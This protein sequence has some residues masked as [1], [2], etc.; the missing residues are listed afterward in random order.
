MYIK[1]LTLQQILPNVDR[2]LYVDTD[3]LFLG[4]PIAIWQTFGRFDSHH[5]AGLVR[6]TEA[7]SRRGVYSRLLAYPS[8][9]PTGSYI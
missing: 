2:V 5:L 9:R 4:A 1:H 7:A 3:I 6:E 8:Y